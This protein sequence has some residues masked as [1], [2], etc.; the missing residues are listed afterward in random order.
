MRYTEI[1]ELVTKV[2]SK[3]EVGN[4]VYAESLRKVYGIKR[5]VGVNEYYNATSVG[6][7]LGAEIRIKESSYKGEDE[8]D[9]C[10]ERFSII[11]TYPFNHQDIVVVL[12]HKQGV[13][14]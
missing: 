11:R 2:E 8:A 4:V 13:N 1:L 5:K 10:G 7:T 12:G 14:G 3:D 9:Y 6:I